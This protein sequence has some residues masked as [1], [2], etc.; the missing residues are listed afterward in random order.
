MLKLILVKNS[1]YSAIYLSLF[2]IRLF[3]AKFILIQS[4][5]QLSF[6]EDL[7]HSSTEQLS[8]ADR[9]NRAFVHFFLLSRRNLFGGEGVEAILVFVP[10]LS[11]GL[12]VQVRVRTSAQ[13]KSTAILVQ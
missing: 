1:I 5:Y 10:F 11:F 9:S 7:R 4:S 13:K 6:N 3:P 12:R 8:W 2:N